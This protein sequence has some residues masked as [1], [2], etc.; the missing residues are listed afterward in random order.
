MEWRVRSIQNPHSLSTQKK[1]LK[2][3]KCWLN[4]RGSKNRVNRETSRTSGSGVNSLLYNLWAKVLDDQRQSTDSRPACWLVTEYFYP[5]DY[6]SSLILS[7][8]FQKSLKESI[9]IGKQK[10]PHG[11]CCYMYCRVTIIGH[12]TAILHS[13]KSAFALGLSETQGC[14]K[15]VHDSLENAHYL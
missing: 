14:H 12:K 9:W 10:K 1:T 11:L 5:G 3:R 4:K 6:R 15:N 7:P 2:E 8:S 13:L